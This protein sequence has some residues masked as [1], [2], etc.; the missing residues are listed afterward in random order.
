M[1]NL[2]LRILL[3]V[4][5]GYLVYLTLARQLWPFRVPPITTDRPRWMLGCWLGAAVALSIGLLT[6]FAFGSQQTQ[7]KELLAPV[8]ILV[9]TMAAGGLIAWYHYRRKY[10]EPDAIF[11]SES[12]MVEWIDSEG[13]LHLDYAEPL[14]A[15]VGHGANGA[16]EIATGDNFDVSIYGLNQQE[17]DLAF[18]ESHQACQISI[19]GAADASSNGISTQ[20]GA[21][22]GRNEAQ[23]EKSERFM[24][25]ARE[26]ARQQYNLRC[27]AEKNLRITRRALINAESEHQS[28]N[29]LEKNRLGNLE[30]RLQDQIRQSARSETKLLQEINKVGELQHK[31]ASA[32]DLMLQAKSEVRRHLDARAKALITARKA[33]NFARRSIEARERTEQKM[34]NLQEQLNIQSNT[35][36]TLV[37]SLERSKIKCSELERRIQHANEASLAEKGFRKLQSSAEIRETAPVTKKGASRIIRKVARPRQ[38]SNEPLTR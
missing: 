10:Q 38:A 12:E 11:D 6:Y 36:S 25:H 37:K 2:G 4:I 17:F 13:I 14:P 23:S 1:T 27:E 32:K 29:T 30:E 9:T 3:P 35:T 19:N 8:V 7:L 15:D 5:S 21:Q 24:E 16:T 31:L 26:L 28:Q 33:V 20:A 18:A 22:A 34:K